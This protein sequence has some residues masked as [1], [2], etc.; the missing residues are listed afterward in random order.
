MF[1]RLVAL[2]LEGVST[3]V[4][5]QHVHVYTKQPRQPLLYWLVDLLHQP[6]VRVRL[7]VES[8]GQGFEE[9]L[10]KRI[11]SRLSLTRVAMPVQTV[12]SALA[13]VRAE[14]KRSF[15]APAAW[16]RVEQSGHGLRAALE[17]VLRVNCT[18]VRWIHKF[19]WLLV[20][21]HGHVDAALA[22][23]LEDQWRVRLQSLSEV[24]M[25]VVVAMVIHGKLDLQ[26]SYDAYRKQMVTSG[27]PVADQRMYVRAYHALRDA[28]TLDVP[29][30]VV[31][32]V[33]RDDEHA[34]HWPTYL[35]RWGGSWLE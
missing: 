16:G 2:A 18:D 31:R 27:Y 11:A 17:Q 23:L 5:L 14:L 7:V 22:A 10:E 20:A 15:P 9:A 8:Q 21:R 12:D 6:D 1:N 29:P 25:C 3:V 4:V 24:E 19:C 32:C 35:C 28:G 33:L 13:I 30:H 34:E 26:V